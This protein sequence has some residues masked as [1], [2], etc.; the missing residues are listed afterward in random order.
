MERRRNYFNSQRL[1][2]FDEVKYVGFVF[3]ESEENMKESKKY[4]IR[5]RQPKH[6]RGKYRELPYL[7]GCNVHTDDLVVS[8]HEMENRWREW[9]APDNGEG[10]RNENI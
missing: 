3:L 8:V 7:D 2:Y 4:Y 5:A 10:E 1:L 6:N 9:L